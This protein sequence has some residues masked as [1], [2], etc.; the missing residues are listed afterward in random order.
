MEVILLEKIRNLGDL[1]ESVRVKPGYGRNYLIP[2]GKAVPATKDNIVKFEKQR[3]GL[4]KAQADVLQTAT[5]RA[6]Q[7]NGLK[8]TI[9]R[10]TGTE[11]KLYGSVSTADIAEAVVT[12]GQ[13][14]QKNE[15]VLPDGPFR[16]TGEFEV[17][18]L[19]HADITTS[20]HINIVAE[21][22]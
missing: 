16:Q 15:V 18:L 21:E 19:L 6:E 1:G 22:E 8:V 5:S 20:I 7:L 2:N 4:E 3:A 11:G 10:R 14:L 12:A 13:E 9:A 17:E